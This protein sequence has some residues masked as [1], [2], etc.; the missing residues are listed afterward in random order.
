[1]IQFSG[2]LESHAFTSIL[3]LVAR[4]GQSGRLRVER[5]PLVGHIDLQNGHVLSAVCGAVQGLD[6]LETL[7]L[8]PAPVD[9]VFTRGLLGCDGPS[10][11]LAPDALAEYLTAIEPRRRRI[12]AAVP[13]LSGRVL[14]VAPTPRDEQEEVTLTRRHL[15][16]LFQVDGSHTAAEVLVQLGTVQGMEAL[17]DLVEQQVVVVEQSSSATHAV[18]VVPL[19]VAPIPAADVTRR[20]RLRVSARAVAWTGVGLFVVMS[21]A[22]QLPDIVRQIQSSSS[23]TSQQE[24][25]LSTTEATLADVPPSLGFVWPSDSS[26]SFWVAVDGYHLASRDTDRFVAVRPPVAAYNRDVAVGGRFRV[27][28]GPPG[29]THGL[30]VRDLGLEERDGV[31]QTGRFLL[32]G[33]T[34]DGRSVVRRREDD[35]WIEVASG[36]PVE[37]ARRGADSSYL[38]VVAIGS[39][40]TFRIGE[41]DVIK[42]EDTNPTIGGIGLFAD[43]GVEVLVDQLSLRIIP[44]E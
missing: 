5:Q 40:V 7:I 37:S 18:D 25:R 32:F 8:V 41:T 44:D 20:H 30:I 26:A 34:G 6:A 38:E 22:A 39:K 3:L 17:A 35:R 29:A 12:G 31:N 9:F 10:L 33:L 28:N 23:Q 36:P 14:L 16:L 42:I 27:V 11:D 1:V 4:L 15:A 43:G 21:G 2:R 19:D 13:S 24:N